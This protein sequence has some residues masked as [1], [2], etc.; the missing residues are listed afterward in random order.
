MPPGTF[1]NDRDETASVLEM[2]AM[3]HGNGTTLSGAKSDSPGVAAR[4]PAAQ[5]WRTPRDKNSVTK[6]W[7]RHPLVGVRPCPGFFGVLRPSGSAEGRPDT[8]VQGSALRVAKLSPTKRLTTGGISAVVRQQTSP[9]CLAGNG[10]RRTT[11]PSLTRLLPNPPEPAQDTAQKERR[12]RF[13][14]EGS[15]SNGRGALGST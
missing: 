3:P 4:A 1:P 5:C 7:R 12:R 15:T 8:A 11:R 10:G 14:R 13:P 9:L 6:T 2:E